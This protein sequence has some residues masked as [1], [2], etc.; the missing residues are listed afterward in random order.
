[1]IVGEFAVQYNCTSLG[2]KSISRRTYVDCVK[3]KR[4][5]HDR[6]VHSKPLPYDDGQQPSIRYVRLGS[7]LC[8]QLFS[9]ERCQTTELC[10]VFSLIYQTFVTDREAY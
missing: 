7:L 10:I 2:Q 3:F 5:G 8:Q 4:S 6:H 9:K 1:M